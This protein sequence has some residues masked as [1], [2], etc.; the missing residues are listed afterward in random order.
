MFIH[1]EVAGWKECEQSIHWGCQRLVPRADAEAEVPAIQMVG[2]RTT[3][4]EI[5]EI[6]NEVYQQRRLPGSPLY[7]PEWMEALDQE[8]CASLEEWMQWMWGTTRPEEE[9]E[10][11]TTSILWSSCQTKSPQV[12]SQGPGKEQRPT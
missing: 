2:F 8:I 9:L 4:E 6:Y 5:Q 11:N 12:P 3:K 10:G 1:A 7:G